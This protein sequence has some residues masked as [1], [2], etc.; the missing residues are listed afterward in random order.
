MKT[1]LNFSFVLISVFFALSIIPS[2]AGTLSLPTISTSAMPHG[3]LSGPFGWR[4]F[5]Q[6]YSDECIAKNIGSTSI[7]LT[8]EVWQTI[9]QI[10]EWVN[11]TIQPV[12]DY[13]HWGVP[14]SWDIPTDGK[15]D[16]ED[17]ALLKRQTLTH[18]GLPTAALLMTVVYNRRHEGHAI[19]TL[20]TD[21]GD[22]ILDNQTDT[23]MGWKQTGYRFIER[24]SS[25]NPNIWVR[26]DDNAD[27][28]VVSS[29]KDTDRKILGQSDQ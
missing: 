1:K 18:L 21:R 6:K 17:Y 16:C 3:T 27:E 23:I 4:D 24:Q 7:N 12:S 19:L 22:Y 11:H 9:R 8:S 2:R 15:G 13:D 28:I 29:R 10:N 5:C 25:G 26:L 14:E 20:V